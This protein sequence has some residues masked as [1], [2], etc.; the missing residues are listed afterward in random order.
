MAESVAV[1]ATFNDVASGD[2]D[3]T[4]TWAEAGSLADDKINPDNVTI[5]GYVVNI[6]AGGDASNDTIT[7]KLGGTLSANEKV[8]AFAGAEID[9]DGGRFHYENGWSSF[10]V[11]GNF[12]V[13]AD[14]KFDHTAWTSK[15]T[16]TFGTLNFDVGN[17]TLTFTNTGGTTSAQFTKFVNGTISKSGTLN[18]QG[19]LDVDTWKI[20]HCELSGFTLLPAVTLTK[21][22][23]SELRISGNSSF[24]GTVVVNAGYLTTIVA[25]GMTGAVIAVN[26]GRLES[27]VANGLNGAMLTVN[28]GGTLYGN[29]PDGAWDGG[30]V[31]LNGGNVFHDLNGGLALGGDFRVIADSTFTVYRWTSGRTGIY[32]GLDFAAGGHMLCVTNPEARLETGRFVDSIVCNSGTID[33]GDWTAV[34]LD[35]LAVTV[36]KTLNKTGPNNLTLKTSFGIAIPGGAALVGSAG[37]AALDVTN[38]W[39][40]SAVNY[41]DAGLWQFDVDTGANGGIDATMTNLKDTVAYPGHGSPFAAEDAGYVKFTGLVEGREM[42]IKV[43]LTNI[44]DIDSVLAGL[45]GNPLYTEIEAVGSDAVRLRLIPTWSG[46]GYFVWDNA[47]GAAHPLGA[48]VTRVSPMLLPGTVLT[49]F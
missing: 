13:T 14:S 20:S 29:S 39:S 42:M 28:A 18:V 5:D 4:A 15:S 40:Q 49:L 45:G 2:Y 26:G 41:R 11:G 7:I 23:G 17:P 32:G 31:L 19:Y 43:E 10:S 6:A 1:G 3:D 27:D 25:G 16:T 8:N 24:G 30:T 33:V 48:D 12:L 47:P 36:G 34:E 21:D 38:G 35:G 9:L 44:T 22:G 37:F 46:D